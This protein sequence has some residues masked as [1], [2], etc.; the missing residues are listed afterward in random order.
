MKLY[1][2]T[3][4]LEEIE[5]IAK[6]GILDGVTTNPTLVSLENVDFKKRIKSILKILSKNCDDDF[7]VSAEVTSSK[8]EEMIK[9]GKDLSKIDSHILV[10]IPLTSEGLIAIKQLSKLGIRTNVTLC[11]NA[12]QALLAAK[13]GAYI[14]SPFI[15]RLEDIGQD[16]IKLVSEIRQIYDLYGFKTKILSASIRTLKQVKDVSLIGSDIATIPYRVFTKLWEDH[17]TTVGLKKFESDWKKYLEN[18]KK[19]D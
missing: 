9:E 18:I 17:L 10:K 16:G 14:I 5:K 1:L 13:A 19:N 6:L 11:F 4:N 7:T 12:N 2:D 15:G 8:A 3:G